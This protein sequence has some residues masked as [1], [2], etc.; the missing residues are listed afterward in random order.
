MILFIIVKLE[1]FIGNQTDQNEKTTQLR[2]EF[3]VNR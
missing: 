2:W 1:P 3:L